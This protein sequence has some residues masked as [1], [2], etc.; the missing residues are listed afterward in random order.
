M[1]EKKLPFSTQYIPAPPAVK[2]ETGFSS[3]K[4]E[5]GFAILT[6][7]VSVLLVNAILLGGL[8]LG[9]GVLTIVSICATAV[10]LLRSGCRLTGYSG[11]LLGLSIV[12]SASFARSD[13]GFVKFVMFCFLLLSTN[14]GLCLLAGQNRHNPAGILSLLDAFRAALMLGVG[15][16]GDSFRGL[17][18]AYRQRSVSGKK[19]GAVLVGLLIAVPILVVLIFLLMRADAAFEGLVD[20]L[21]HVDLSEIY[22]SLMIGV[23]LACVLYTRGVALKQ[24]GKEAPAQIAF[25]SMNPVTVNTVLWA[26]C[27]VYAV[28]LLSQLA[29]FVGG[30]AGI[31]P[32]EYTMA[33][34]ARRG[35]FEMAW[36]CAINL[37]LIALAV[38]L[39]GEKTGATTKGLCLFIGVVTLFFVVTASAKM[40]LYIDSYGLTRLRVLTEI[41]MVFL[42][43]TTIFVCVWLFIPKFA[44]MKAVLLMA[45]ALGAA[46]AWADVDTVVAAY[47]V[48]A[49]RSGQMAAVDVDYLGSLS[50]GAIPYIAQLADDPNPDVAAQARNILRSH[51]RHMPES[52]D[53]RSFNIATML[54]DQIA[55]PYE[56]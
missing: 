53:L 56:P 28:Y 20:L 30:F 51:R 48:S 15:K 25:K 41:I 46:T 50:D 40:L 9:F 7:I 39:S 1:D 5:L 49:Y 2:P 36:L 11:A 23:P 32:A 19:Q 52:R 34:Y 8:Q 13:D 22:V 24:A 38:A 47:N 29:Y 6:T 27:G 16:L 43:L 45:L 33:E 18:A 21:P 14:L 26:V 37:G 54:A 3:G 42:A 44:Y 17:R 12:I 55:S 35:F 10:Y 31:L 4:R